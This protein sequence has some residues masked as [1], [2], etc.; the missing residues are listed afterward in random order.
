MI[1]QLPSEGMVNDETDAKALLERRELG[2]EAVSS[3]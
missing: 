2:R 1:L 3:I